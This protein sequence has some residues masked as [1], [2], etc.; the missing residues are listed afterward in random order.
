[1]GSIVTTM[2]LAAP[3]ACAVSTAVA[4]GS[5]AARLRADS[6]CASNSVSVW[7]A[8]ARCVAIGV[9]ITPRPMNPIF[10]ETMAIPRSV[11]RPFGRHAGT[12]LTFHS[13]DGAASPEKPWKP[14]ARGHRDA[15]DNGAFHVPSEA[16]P[17][18]CRGFHVRR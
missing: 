16:E 6:A 13:V 14:H 2:S 18:N 5:S 1:L 3:T 12:R 4:P 10:N 7:P 9:P 8:L 11:V 17:L 15:V